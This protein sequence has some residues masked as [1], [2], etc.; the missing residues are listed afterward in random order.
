MKLKKSI[1]LLSLILFATAGSAFA[2]SWSSG[3][4]SAVVCFNDPNIVARV[5]ARS[6]MV[7]AEEL[8][9]IESIEMLDLFEWKRPRGMEG[10]PNLPLAEPM[11]GEKYT[12]F[13]KRI[14]DR[15]YNTIGSHSSSL[16]GGIGNYL[17][18]YQSI[19]TH[20]IGR[21][22]EW[23]GTSLVHLGD[24][25]T[26]IRF[27]GNCTLVPL[28]VQE[29]EGFDLRLFID[30]RLFFHPKHSEQ[31]K[32]ALFI[33]EFLYAMG[34]KLGQTD[35]S[36]TRLAVG[37]M[38]QNAPDVRIVDVLERLKD[39]GFVDSTPAIQKLHPYAQL[40]LVSELAYILHPYDRELTPIWM[41]DGFRAAPS[42]RTEGE[43]SAEVLALMRE[44]G[45]ENRETRRFNANKAIA[46]VDLLPPS[47]KREAL[48]GELN[49]IIAE[50]ARFTISQ[51]SKKLSSNHLRDRLVQ[52]GYIPTQQIDAWLNLINGPIFQEIKLKAEAVG[53]EEQLEQR[54]RQKSPLAYPIVSFEDL[55][56]RESPDGRFTEWHYWLDD[57]I[58]YKATRTENM[59]VDPDGLRMPQL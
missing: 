56:T 51:L 57:L 40:H 50:R 52:L 20:I 37:W 28:A 29:G 5:K 25:G 27:G 12:S 49:A 59:S 11:P 21:N 44:N 17:Y 15:A 42:S 58:A 6:G 1:L 48:R 24:E 31:S 47:E 55:F 18:T 43:V 26:P 39:I 46:Y 36:R 38:M 30:D 19:F 4:G 13:V 32:A 33:H 3:G 34:R 9:D 35:S 16:E 53:T 23:T 10:T 14:T 54:R 45:V 41:D 22:I 2:G 8:N 7:M